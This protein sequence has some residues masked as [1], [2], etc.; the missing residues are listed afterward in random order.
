MPIKINIDQ[1]RCAAKIEK[2]WENSLRPLSIQVLSDCNRY[3]KIDRHT[4]EA[5]SYSAS[6]FED[7]VLIWDTKYAKRQYWQIQ[8]SLTPGRTWKWCETAKKKHRIDW[9]KIAEKLLRSNL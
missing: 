8:T 2:A 4:M 1:N 5:S 6:R 7:G 3:V 9:A